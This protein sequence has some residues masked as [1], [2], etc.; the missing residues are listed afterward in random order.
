MNA[1]SCLAL[2]R[3]S[4]SSCLAHSWI[5]P[6]CRRRPSL[7]EPSESAPYDT[8]PTKKW[9]R[10]R[11]LPQRGA[12]ALRPLRRSSFA[13]I[14]LAKCMSY[15][16]EWLRSAKTGPTPGAR[17]MSKRAM[18]WET[19][20]AGRRIPGVREFQMQL[21]HWVRPRAQI[22]VPSSV[23]DLRSA[24]RR[25]QIVVRTLR[26][27]MRSP[28]YQVLRSELRKLSDATGPSR[29]AYVR[30]RIGRRV[31]KSRHAVKT[32]PRK[33]L[34]IAMGRASRRATIGLRRSADRR[35]WSVSMTRLM[36][37]LRELY[38]LRSFDGDVR[39]AFEAEFNRVPK[40]VRAA[41][42]GTL[43]V[44]ERVHPLRIKIRNARYLGEILYVGDKARELP[45]VR[46]LHSWKAHWAKCTT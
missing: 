44:N 40:K 7:A 18:R 46:H 32:R 35:S 34:M 39:A 36:R 13:V 26:G 4:W 12:P 25:L 11:L 20:N 33:A 27:D 1:A 3:S 41:L 5:T 31:L 2:S 23:H 14:S 37:A 19:R 6:V 30:T 29:E 38:C 10:F 43:K 45:L 16:S 22:T 24:T 28:L 9:V 15:L 17:R 42:K 8:A 21:K